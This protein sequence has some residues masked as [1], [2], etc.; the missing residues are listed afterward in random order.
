MSGLSE[1]DTKGSQ[2]NG[3][4]NHYGNAFHS[5]KMLHQKS[6]TDVSSKNGSS[7]QR[8]PGRGSSMGGNKTGQVRA[9][10]PQ[11]E[12]NHGETN[13]FISNLKIKSQRINASPR[14]QRVQ[15]AQPRANQAKKGL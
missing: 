10:R 12:S 7:M 15:T 14:Q 1:Y 4:L 9:M 13:D 2:S 6:G 8:L 5:R 3:V 11:Y